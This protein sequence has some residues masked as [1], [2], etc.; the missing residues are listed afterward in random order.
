[1]GDYVKKG[2]TNKDGIILVFIR[3]KGTRLFTWCFDVFL[4]FFK[5]VKT[6]FFAILKP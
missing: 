4:L 2:L 3:V 6:P 1:M 5:Q